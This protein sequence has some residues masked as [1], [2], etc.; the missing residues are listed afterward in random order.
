MLRSSASFT[1]FTLAT[2]A[3]AILIKYGYVLFPQ[4]T[5]AQLQVLERIQTEIL[6]DGL[7]P[8]PPTP[9]NT[10]TIAGSSRLQTAVSLGLELYSRTDTS[11][12]G[13]AYSAVSSASA[14]AQ[15]LQSSN[16]RDRCGACVRRGHRCNNLVSAADKLQVLSTTTAARADCASI[17]RAN[18]RS[19]SQLHHFPHT[20][21]TH[22][23]EHSVRA[24]ERL[25]RLKPDK[26][27]IRN[28]LLCS[29]LL[30]SI[31]TSL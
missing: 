20:R 10:L 17:Q 25:G 3:S 4:L 13:Y 31:Q 15:L 27:L 21:H 7:P 28:S 2:S 29:R 6:C 11:G 16:N 5:L 26:P 22:S 14:L 12:L 1:T 23:G 19:H 9:A 8:S 18:L 30:T 24:A